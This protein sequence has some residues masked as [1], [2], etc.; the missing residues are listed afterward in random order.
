[1]HWIAT[2][3]A[4]VGLLGC[5]GDTEQAGRTLEMLEQAQ[6]SVHGFQ[7][8]DVA[9]AALNKTL[10]KPDSTEGEAWMWTSKEGEACHTLTVTRI[11]TAVGSVALEPSDCP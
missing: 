1:M 4:V 5:G 2:T 8:W 3:V 7:P 6:H 10:G 9:E 11:G